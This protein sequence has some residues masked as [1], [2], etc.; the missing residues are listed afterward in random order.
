MASDEPD[1]P[2][3][4]PTEEWAVECCHVIGDGARYIDPRMLQLLVRTQLTMHGLHIVDAKDWAVLEA[5]SAMTIGMPSCAPR[6][7]AKM[8]PIPKAGVM[9]VVEAELARREKA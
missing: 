4:P 2:E 8:G 9:R 3:G 5:C 7:P 6:P 1:L